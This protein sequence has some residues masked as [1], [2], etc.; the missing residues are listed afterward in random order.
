MA[1]MLAALPGWFEALNDPQPV[2]ALRSVVANELATGASMGDVQEF[3]EQRSEELYAG[4]HPL[5]A[6]VVD[7]VLALMEGW[8]PTDIVFG[9]A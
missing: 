1:T 6:A 2:L 9:T 4:G 3:L 7:E 8:G 5:D